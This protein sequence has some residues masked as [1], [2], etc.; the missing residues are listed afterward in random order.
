MTDITAAG[1]FPL[2][3]RTVRL[4]VDANSRELFTP[5]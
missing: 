1:A 5:L 2:A 4:E 3:D